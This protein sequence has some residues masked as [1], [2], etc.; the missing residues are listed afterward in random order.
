VGESIERSSQ[1]V[2]SARPLCA[3][4]ATTETD[5]QAQ[6][7]VPEG[8]W[9]AFLDSL[10]T[11]LPTTFRV[12]GSR[13]HAET[14]NNL[15]KE[16][17]VPTMQDVELD[18]IKYDAPKPMSWYPGELAWEVAAPK[19]VVRKQPAFKLFQRFL[20]GETGVGNLSRQEAVS[21]IPPLLMDVQPHHRCLDMCAAPG[22]KT[23][24]II[25]A[26]NPYHTE[27]TGMLIANDADYKRTHMLVHQTGRMPTK[28]LV[29]TNFDASE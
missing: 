17:Y 10:R 11:E 13:E 1:T 9:D 14:I 12:T 6:N 3:T 29:V 20:V 28:G 15:I 18:G 25:E 16:V 22:S 21:M 2:I 24:Q 8:E 26:L 27:S 7:I 23:A 5:L 4:Q 19:R